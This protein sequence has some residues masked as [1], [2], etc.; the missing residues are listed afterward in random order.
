MTQLIEENLLTLTHTFTNKSLLSYNTKISNLSWNVASKYLGVL[1][2]G[3]NFIQHKI[4]LDD[5]NP[6]VLSQ[7]KCYFKID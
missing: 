3:Y 5:L 2:L 4:I 1:K 7:L 6:Y